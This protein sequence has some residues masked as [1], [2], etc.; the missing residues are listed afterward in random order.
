MLFGTGAAFV[1]R[2]RRKPGAANLALAAGFVVVLMCA[3]QGLKV[4]YPILGSE[5]LAEVINQ[6]W[7]PASSIVID[8]EYTNNSS[9][10]FY[11]QQPVLML[12][13]RVNGLWYGSLF[14]DAPDRFLDDAGFASLWNGEAQV[15]FV[16]DKPDRA[17]RLLGLF[18][19]GRV[20]AQSGGKLLLDND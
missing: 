16:T 13:G 9:L 2:L 5:P 18:H 12:N 14:P 4:F 6:R 11:T 17:R 1:L 15:F 7:Q 10:N 19:R 20:I 3:H 8:G